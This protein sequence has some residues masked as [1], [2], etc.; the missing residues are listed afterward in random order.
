MVAYARELHDFDEDPETWPDIAIPMLV[1][2]RLPYGWHSRIGSVF[3]AY[4]RFLLFGPGA[5]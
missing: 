3:I 4:G 2:A 5:T 1:L